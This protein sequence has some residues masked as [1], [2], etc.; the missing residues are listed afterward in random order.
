MGNVRAEPARPLA[1]RAAGAVPSYR[2]PV[3]HPDAG[4]SRPPLR[5]V[6]SSVGAL[7]LVAVV[8]TMAPGLLVYVVLRRLGLAI[9]P[10][11]LLGLLAMFCGCFAYCG[12]LFRGSRGGR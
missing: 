6:R 11:G 8:V 3:A 12:W 1:E 7:A 2:G 10:A 5:G 4:Q 9:G